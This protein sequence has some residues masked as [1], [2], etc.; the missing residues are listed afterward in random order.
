MEFQ[1]P[2]QISVELIPSLALIT[3]NK[4]DMPVGSC[5]MKWLIGVETGRLFGICVEGTEIVTRF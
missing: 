4:S 3:V 1:F 2:L 5:F